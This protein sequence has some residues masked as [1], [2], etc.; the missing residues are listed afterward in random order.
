MGISIPDEKA[1]DKIQHSFLIKIFS[2]VE[3]EEN[4]LNLIRSINEKPTANITL[5]GDSPI[6]SPYRNKARISTSTTSIQQCT[7]GF[8]RG[9]K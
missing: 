9:K 3:I 2:R 5:N 4:L 1:L 6:L 7:G 8:A